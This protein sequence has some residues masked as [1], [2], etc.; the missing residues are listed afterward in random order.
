MAELVFAYPSIVQLSFSF[1]G[2][3]ETI[4]C[5]SFLYYTLMMS[6]LMN[7]DAGEAAFQAEVTGGGAHDGNI[8]RNIFTAEQ[9]VA[10][11][12]NFKIQYLS[13]HQAKKL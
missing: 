6:Q 1:A 5:S 9:I 3:G 10:K 7:I 12:G 2:L 4:T 8:W 11:R 13:N